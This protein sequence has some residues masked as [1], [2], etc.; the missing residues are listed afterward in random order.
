MNYLVSYN[1]SG[2]TWVR[3]CVEYV[4]KLPTHGYRKFSI[5]ERHQNF[6]DI[7]VDAEPVLIKRH[8]I[9]SG[10]ILKND[11]FILLLRD[12]SKCIKSDQDVHKEFLRYYSLIK[13]YEAHEGPKII[14]W[15][16]EILFS[17]WIR[18]FLKHCDV[19]I[20]IDQKKLDNLL[21]TWDHHQKMCKGIYNNP[22]KKEG[23][24]LS[25]IPKI[26]L[27]HELIKNTGYTVHV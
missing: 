5:S 2:N 27:E 11:T 20:D 21:E 18:N 25:V 22:I 13:Y 7:D 4:T 16:D 19:G 15:Y 24:D 23:A 6:L 1:H 26:L 12:P 8:E 9:I 14:C 17:Y 10:E 3:Y